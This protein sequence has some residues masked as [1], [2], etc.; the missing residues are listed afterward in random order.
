MDYRLRAIIKRF[1][2]ESPR[3]LKT[4]ARLVEYLIR[5]LKMVSDEADEIIT[6]LV[7]SKHLNESRVQ[8]EDKSGELRPESVM[9]PGPALGSAVFPGF[10]TII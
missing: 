3:Q 5:H 10:R 7:E 9:S 8:T 1:F 2:R 6:A 4:R